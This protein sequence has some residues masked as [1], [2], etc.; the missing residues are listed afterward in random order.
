MSERPNDQ[1]VDDD[2]EPSGIADGAGDADAEAPDLAAEDAEASADELTADE[3]EDDE[4]TIEEGDAAL[5]AASDEDL[6]LPAADEGK[7]EAETQTRPMRPSERRAMRAAL[8]HGRLTLDPAHRV[9]DRASAVFV[10][11]TVGA[12]VLILLNGLVLGHGGFLTPIPTASPIPSVTASPV[13]SATAAPSGSAA[14]IPTPTVAPTATPEVTSPPP[15][16]TP[17]PS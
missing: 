17:G 5:Q 11:V 2:L 3:L 4:P 14:A 10:L 9:S 16:A 1:P 13:P 6:G 12:F 15:S 8:D 7:V